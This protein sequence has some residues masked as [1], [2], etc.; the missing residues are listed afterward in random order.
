MIGTMTA[1]AAN[2]NPAIAVVIVQAKIMTITDVREISG[3]A[4]TANIAAGVEPQMSAL[5]AAEGLAVATM[6]PH[7]NRVA[8]SAAAATLD[9]HQNSVRAASLANTGEA[10]LAVTAVLCPAA[11]LVRTVSETNRTN[12]RR[13][14]LVMLAVAVMGRKALEKGM[15]PALM[16]AAHIEMNR[17]G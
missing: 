7:M 12:P 3:D 11:G 13:N 4:T 10:A 9:G 17:P 16:L 2:P 8:S 1:M 6:G 14:D 5:G 15:R